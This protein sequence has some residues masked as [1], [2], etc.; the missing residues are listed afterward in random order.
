MAV[1]EYMSEALLAVPS[2]SVL[3]NLFLVRTEHDFLREI[4]FKI[5]LA[6][7]QPDFT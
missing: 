2:F 4:G 5:H 3:P 6:V 7:E 1:H